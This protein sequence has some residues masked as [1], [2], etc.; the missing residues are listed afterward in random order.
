MFQINK[1]VH[2]K[3]IT[4]VSIIVFAFFAIAGIS[5]IRSNNTNKGIPLTIA[6]SQEPADINNNNIVDGVDLSLLLSKWN[7]SGN[8]SDINNDGIVNGIDLS[9]LL[10]KW[11]KTVAQT[12]AYN[13]VWQ[14]DFG[15]SSTIADIDRNLWIIEDHAESMKGEKQVFKDLQAQSLVDRTV[16]QQNGQLHLIAK[17]ITGVSNNSADT[18]VG[19]S[20]ISRN[21]E[22]YGRMY[23]RIRLPMKRFGD[24]GAP[25]GT[26]PAFWSLGKRLWIDKPWPS[27]GE[28]DFMEHVDMGNWIRASVHNNLRNGDNSIHGD[29]SNEPAFNTNTWFIYGIDWDS[30]SVKFYAVKDPNQSSNTSIGTADSLWSSAPINTIKKSDLPAGANPVDWWPF[31]DEFTMIL[32]LSVGG[33]WVDYEYQSRTGSAINYSNIC[34]DPSTSGYQEKGCEMLVDWVRVEQP[35]GCANCSNGRM[36]F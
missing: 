5:F 24:Y 8:S 4:F 25:A 29:Y 22:K 17:Y 28:L 26:F 2:I 18:H 13:T 35:S 9:I 14:D 27:S 12:A 10:G 16:F 1:K 30:E 19:A 11:G 34:N 20:I 7:T 21:T 3:F 15:S 23:G 33:G 32:N 36:P 31:D 6:S